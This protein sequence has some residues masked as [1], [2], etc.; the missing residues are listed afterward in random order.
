MMRWNVA[1]KRETVAS[2]EQATE[3]WIVAVTDEEGRRAA[4]VEVMITD[5]A[6]EAGRAHVVDARRTGGESAVLAVLTADP[7][8][9]PTTILI[10]TDGTQPLYD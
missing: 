1:S 4:E 6:V 9:V 3:G 7:T 2:D 5:Q 8:R 10:G